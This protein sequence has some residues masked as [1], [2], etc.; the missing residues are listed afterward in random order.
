MTWK[1]DRGGKAKAGTVAGTDGG[2]GIVINFKSPIKGRFQAHRLI[3]LM[4]TGEDPGDLEIDHKNRDPKDNRWDNLRL[5]SRSQNCANKITKKRQ[6]D[7][8][9]G[10]SL[11]KHNPN[12]PFV[13]RVQLTIGHFSTAE[14]A[15]QAYLNAAEKV[16]GEFARGGV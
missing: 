8:P 10:V 12:K 6:R 3:W 15:H 14:E 2:H 4:V 1:L 7:L 9:K 11:T 13:A 16:F 5:S